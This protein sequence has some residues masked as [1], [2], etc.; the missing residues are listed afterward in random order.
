MIA[1]S[2]SS[3]NAGFGFFGQL[4]PSGAYAGEQRTRIWP[5]GGGVEVGVGVGVEVGG[6]GGVAGGGVGVGGGVGT[7][8]TG[9][10]MGVK[11]PG[12]GDAVGTLGNSVIVWQPR[13]ARP[14]TK[15]LDNDA[16]PLIKP[17]RKNVIIIALIGHEYKEKLRSPKPLGGESNAWLGSSPP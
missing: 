15:A 14:A 1:A 10:W 5:P 7:F 8:V 16:L 13:T 3:T 6:G 17:L 12:V 2:T 9:I 4:R 11:T